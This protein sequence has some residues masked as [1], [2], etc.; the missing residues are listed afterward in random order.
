MDEE[1]SEA[2]DAGVGVEAEDVKDS[3]PKLSNTEAMEVVEEVEF[4]VKAETGGAPD[5]E[6]FGG[7][8]RRGPPPD[9]GGASK[10]PLP[11]L[12]FFSLDRT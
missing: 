7:L 9:G 5:A 12:A 3:W 4:E 2:L 10:P 6:S 11:V 1:N 8:L